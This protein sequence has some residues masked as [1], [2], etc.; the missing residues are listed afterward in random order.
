[1]NTNHWKLI[2]KFIQIDKNL[3]YNQYLKS[4]KCILTILYIFFKRKKV[5]NVK[6]ITKNILTPF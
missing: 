6:C 4:K 2:G 3:S 5:K 1:M